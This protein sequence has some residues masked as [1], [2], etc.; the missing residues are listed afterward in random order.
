MQDVAVGSVD[1]GVVGNAPV[2][3]HGAQRLFALCFAVG[4]P[5]GE[6]GV[7]DQDRLGAH[8][9]GVYPAA[10][11]V[12][13]RERFRA[14][15]PLAGAVAGGDAA[16]EGLGDMQ[17]DEGPFGGDGVEPAPVQVQRRLGRQPGADADARGPERHG[18]AG[19]RVVG[20][21]DGVDDVGDAGIDDRLR[22]GAGAPT[23]VA[24]LQR[25]HDRRA[26]EVPAR[27]FR[28]ADGVGFGVGSPGAAV[29]T[30]GEV[31]PVGPDDDGADERVGAPRALRRG[32]QGSLHRSILGSVERGSAGLGSAGRGGAESGAHAGGVEGTHL[33]TTGSGKAVSTVTGRFASLEARHQTKNPARVKKP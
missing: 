6:P 18:A 4:V 20:I 33:A 10:Q 32:G 31:R 3:H 8:Q 23:V 17:G 5:G 14:G 27:R 15:D 11:G 25:H 12:V 21:V 7:V 29:V 26:A 16:V 22:A 13:V 1:G 19:G 28:L 24:G 9:D 2:P 30:G